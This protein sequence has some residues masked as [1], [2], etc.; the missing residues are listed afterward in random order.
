MYRGVRARPSIFEA[1]T[2]EIELDM[3]AGE[4][5]CGQGEMLCK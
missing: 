3:I 1:T 2:R 5:E 4:N